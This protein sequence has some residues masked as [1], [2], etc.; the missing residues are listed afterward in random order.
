MVMIKCDG[1]LNGKPATEFYMNKQ[2]KENLDIELS[3]MKQSVQDFVLVIDGQE[4][5]GKSKKA[6]QIAYY[7]S[8]KLGSK[9]DTD[10]VN[11]IHNDITKYID[12][13]LAAG[14]FAV[15]ILDESRH[16][17]LKITS[18]SRSAVRFTNF[19]SECR[20]LRQVHIILLPAYHDLAKYVVLWRMNFLVHLKKKMILDAKMEGGYR[21]VLGEYLVFPN[22]SYTKYFY[23]EKYKYNKKFA[24]RDRFPNFEILTDKGLK[25]YESQKSAL[26]SVKY[27]SSGQIQVGRGDNGLTR[28]RRLH[29][30]MDCLTCPKC[31]HD[32]AI[33]Q[34][35]RAELF[36][37]S[38]PTINQSMK[39]ARE[40]AP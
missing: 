4:G 20:G 3:S 29:R 9:F 37:V 15:N 7:C 30:W 32:Y 11:N 23:D 21:L 17:L 18:N 8:Q 1:T 26:L 13:S 40:T 39:I 28:I 36:G 27:G 2:L 35:D 5:S 24:V 34:K 10:G 25:A 6:R 22:D 38:Q 31:K 33:K 19:L 16:A 14:E 12:T